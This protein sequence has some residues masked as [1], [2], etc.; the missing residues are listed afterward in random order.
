[1]KRLGLVLALLF[2]L[3]LAAVGYWYINQ[4]KTAADAFEKA[5]KTETRLDEELRLAREADP[6]DQEKIAALEQEIR[7]TWT[8]FIGL[9]PDSEEADVARY[10]LLTLDLDSAAPGAERLALIDEFLEAHP[11]HEKLKDLLWQRA[12]ILRDEIDD[13]LVAIEA[14]Q[15]IEATFPEDEIAARAALAAARIYDAIG[16]PGAAAQAYAELAEKYPDSAEAQQALMRQAALLEEQLDRKK[17][18]ADV[19]REVAQNNPGSSMGRQ[20]QSRRKRLLGEIGEGEQDEYYD[21]TYQHTEIAPYDIS[22]EEYNHPTR[23]KIRDQGFDIEHFDVNIRLDPVKKELTA[24]TLLRGLIRKP[25]SGPLLL[26]LN[27]MLKIERVT[28]ARANSDAEADA[29]T[30]NFSHKNEFI[31]LCDPGFGNRQR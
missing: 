21:Q 22:Q 3:G 17:E 11:E 29:E 31:E 16:E 30:V 19:Y 20:A 1:M 10:R 23:L 7:E 24:Q 15:E 28:R 9:W 12:E 4:P 13:P 27:P 6:L 25:L 2:V 14:F 8:D 5:S 18:A 26:E